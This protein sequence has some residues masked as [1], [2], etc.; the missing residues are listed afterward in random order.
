MGLNPSTSHGFN[1]GT[2]TRPLTIDLSASSA[3]QRALHVI[4]P[5]TFDFSVEAFTFEIA[6]QFGLLAFDT[7]GNVSTAGNALATKG[8]D[9]HTRGGP[10][11]VQTAL[12]A[13]V[14]SLDASGL[15]FFGAAAGAKQTGV[16]VTAAGIHAAL[17]TLGLIAA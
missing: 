10:I 9:I 2:I 5:S 11:T 7:S 13:S 6:S 1:G 8:G 17:V 14:H 16:P 12:G 15:G 4:L 3:N